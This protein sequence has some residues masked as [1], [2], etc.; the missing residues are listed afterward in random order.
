[1]VAAPVRRN[2][3]KPWNPGESP[4]GFP[5]S[6]GDADIQRPHSINLSPDEINLP[7]ES[8]LDKLLSSTP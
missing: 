6:R 7:S 3:D 8:A 2:A 1:M 5:V 4:D